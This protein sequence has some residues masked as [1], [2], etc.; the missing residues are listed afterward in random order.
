M[1]DILVTDEQKYYAEEMVS[2]YNFGMRGYGDGNQKEQLTGIIGQTVLSDLLG[3]P[4]PT[5]ADGFDNGVDF[6]INGQKVDIKTMSRTVPVKPHY[7]HN[8]IGY[9]KNYNVGFYIFASYNTRT[10]VLS[11]CGFVSKEEFLE[12]ARFYKK[13]DLRYRDDGT[14]FPTK[15]PLYEIQ[16]SDLNP[17]NSLQELIDG[18]V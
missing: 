13:G 3:V 9:Q 2:R 8:F 14:S 16:Q 15:A 1:F 7:V 6:I 17:T 12:R 11:F 5:G 10:E 18:I 4:R